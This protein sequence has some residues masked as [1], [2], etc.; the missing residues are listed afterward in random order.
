MNPPNRFCGYSGKTGKQSC[1]AKC[2]DS[3]NRKMACYRHKDGSGVCIAKEDCPN[4][5]DDDC[6]SKCI[7]GAGCFEDKTCTHRNLSSSSSKSEDDCKKN[8]KQSIDGCFKTCGVSDCNMACHKLFSKDKDMEGWR[9]YGLFDEPGTKHNHHH[10]NSK[11]REEGDW[12]NF[13]LFDE[14]QQT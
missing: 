9:N 10:P 13:D 1:V 7:D 3:S 12:R 4:K 14:P 6:L 5:N 2:A 11:D 8:C